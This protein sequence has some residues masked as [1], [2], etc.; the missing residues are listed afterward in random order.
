MNSPSGDPLWCFNSPPWGPEARRKGLVDIQTSRFVKIWIT[1]GCLM[2]RPY[3]VQYQRK[4]EQFIHNAVQKTLNSKLSNV[5]DKMQSFVRKKPEPRMKT[6]KAQIHCRT[7]EDRIPETTT[8][9]DSYS[10][11]TE[12]N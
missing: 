6:V 9:V 11:L 7:R 8:L 3:C 5:R 10:V 2:S 12:G 4:R 1:I